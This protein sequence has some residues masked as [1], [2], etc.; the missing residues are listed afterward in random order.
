MA[1]FERPGERLKAD[2][3]GAA[4]AAEG[5]ELDILVDPAPLAEHLIGRLDAGNA[6]SGVL[7]GD[8]HEG[9]APGAVGI[10]G[11]RDLHAARRADHDHR[12]VN[13][14]QRLTYRRG[15]AAAEAHAVSLSQRAGLFSKFLYIKRAHLRHLAQEAR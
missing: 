2:I 9:H 11:R 7:K 10:Y 6:R 1:A 4:V 15:R 13:A 3:I 5:D 14:H 8:V 12:V